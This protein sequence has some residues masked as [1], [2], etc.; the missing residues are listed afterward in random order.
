[1]PRFS[2]HLSMLFTEHPFLDRFAAARAAGFE[3]VE[4]WF[5]YE[6]PAGRLAREL[7]RHGLE[8]ALINLPPGDPAA[9]EQGLAALPGREDEFARGVDLALDYARALDC[10][11][12]HAMAGRTPDADPERCWRTYVANL[13]LAAERAAREGRSVV[14]EAINPRDLP[15]YFLHATRDA[16]RA[17]AEVGHPN[18]GLLLD[19]YHC[20]IIE[21][22]LATRVRELMPMVRH[23]QIAGVP[24]RH[25]PDAG[26]VHYPY[27]FDLID[28]LGYRGFI[29]CEYHPAG[30]T[31][32]GLAWLERARRAMSALPRDPAPAAP[33][34]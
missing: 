30:E 23:L 13:R 24:E 19:L 18:L 31:R 27:L 7:R 2:A 5:P 4:Y 9:G 34:T 6:H 12:L 10:R 33:G 3:A 28:A 1:M 29:G 21:G 26:E 20:Q 8:Q 22:D 17:V 16:A 11:C 14:I 15:G 25:E 32:Q